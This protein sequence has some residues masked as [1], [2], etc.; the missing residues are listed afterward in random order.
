MSDDNGTIARKPLETGDWVH[1]TQTMAE[2]AGFRHVSETWYEQTENFEEVQAALAESALG[3]EDL[4]LPLK[5]LAPTVSNGRFVFE[6][7]GGRFL[8]PDDHALG[9][10]GKLLGTGC[11]YP[12]RLA[13]YAHEGDGD[14]LCHALRHGWKH[15][16]PRLGLRIRVDADDGLRGIVPA[17]AVRTE[18]LL[19][20]IEQLF[21]DGRIS[22]RGG[23]EFTFYGNCL[24][25]DTMRRE[26]DSDYGGMVSITNCGLGKVPL[27]LRPSL[28]RAI[29]QNGCIWGQSFGRA[30]Q[31]G[32]RT[33][34][35]ELQRNIKESLTRQLGLIETAIGDLL[36]TR[37]LTTDVPMKPVFAAT[38]QQLKLNKE[39]ATSIL[40]AWHEEKR[41]TP[42]LANS[43]F[44][45]INSITRAGQQHDEKTWVRFDEIGG[46]L[47]RFRRPDWDSLISRARALSFD[48]VEKTFAM[49]S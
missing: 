20:V 39:L 26:S 18:W 38:A 40:E 27:A 36:E 9:Q 45:V 2:S 22:H 21:P 12:L 8:E 37:S 19:K 34:L 14:A 31:R 42:E 1:E 17:G 16:D 43:L 10:F 7:G 33:D 29:C 5:D 15:S 48:K 46:R 13:R 28:Y 32:Q 44:G 49:V 3:Y 47:M 35:V 6:V 24:I 41:E 4:D 30:I 23:D 11:S 25:P